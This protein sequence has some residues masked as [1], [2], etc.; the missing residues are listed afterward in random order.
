MLHEGMDGAVKAS[1][2]LLTDVDKVLFH[3]EDCEIPQ[4]LPAYLG[5]RAE[6]LKKKARYTTENNVLFT[7]RTIRDA[8][9]AMFPVD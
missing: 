3:A 6:V 1:T 8:E 4:N 7:K 5:I 9:Y 2:P